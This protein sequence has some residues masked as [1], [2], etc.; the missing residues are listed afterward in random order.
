MTVSVRRSATRPATF[1]DHL[2]QALELFN[3]HAQLGERSPLATPYLLGAALNGIEPTPQGRGRVLATLITR[4][5]EA[6]WEGP[7]PADGQELLAMAMGE[8]PAAG[9]YDCL[10]LEL[11]YFQRRYRPTPRNQAEIYTD[12]LHISRPTHDRHLRAAV[13][14]L[15]NAL[16]LLLRPAIH[17]EQ[18]APPSH[19]IGREPLIAQA[20][21]NLRGCHAVNLIGRAGVG[22]SALG[23]AIS[24]RWTTPA[25]F[26]YTFRPN[27]NDQLE[28]LLFALGHFLHQQGVSAL[29][30]QLVADRKRATEGTLALGLVLAD[31]ADLTEP[32]L[33]CFDELDVL[34]P[35]FQDQP[36]PEHTALLAFLDGLRGHAPLL[37]IAQRAFWPSGTTYELEELSDQQLAAWLSALEVPHSPADVSHL[38]AYTAGNPRL[39]EL[40][41]ALHQAAPHESFAAVLEQLPR[42]QVLL[43][44]WL[45]LKQRLPQAERRLLHAL[46]VFRAPAPADAWLNGPDAPAA[47]LRQLMARRLVQHDGHGGVALL[48]ALREIIYGELPVEQR[49]EL[50]SQAA[51]VRAERGAYTAAAQHLH[52]AGQPEAAID[53]WYAQRE[54]EINQGQGARALA[55]FSQIS[56]RRLSPHH[57]KQLL[58]IRAELHELAG[59]PAHVASDLAQ[60]E[61]LAS[62]PATPEAMLRLGHA[63]EAQG[64]PEKALLTY[65]SGLDAIHALLRQSAQLHV[66]RSLTSLRQRDMQRAW[67][68]AHLARFH[69]E[70]MV[71]IV[72]DQSGDYATAHQHYRSALAL[73][74]ASGYPAG[75]AQ[76]HHYLALLAGRRQNLAEAQPHFE[77]AI[78]FYEHVGDQ[79]N[80]E[81]VRSNLAS[82]YIQARQFAEALAPATQALRFFE[83]M[84]NSV[85][86]AQNASNLAE[87]HAE[88]GNLDEA[89]RSAQLVLR[90]EEPQSHPYALYTLGTV[91]R[92][93][94][95]WKHAERYY[96][97]SRR[98]AE[99]ND[100]AYLLAFAW[101][102]LGEIARAQGSA[103]RA[104]RAF[105]QAIE[106][107]TRLAIAEEARA[108]ERLLAERDA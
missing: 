46:A 47:A 90:L 70:T 87:A 54:R 85:R 106:I 76:T 78:A 24:A 55:L 1:Y 83:A 43:P 77:Q 74:E 102:A 49:E 30:H 60:A 10:I 92:L 12:I 75:V 5:A 72:H 93:R 13:E 107:F 88:L 98:I 38:H 18:P 3:D 27:L 51:Q 56:Q 2:K 100:D 62:D 35:Q 26:W 6:L 89:E 36:Q 21:G 63:L 80:R 4:A 97:Q 96:D 25:R 52:A 95:Q 23:A 31:L 41:V 20:L 104:E 37:L 28:S 65:Q 69:A 45:R 14:R 29:W 79:V 67:R 34:Q 39:V 42:A 8:V 15:G 66:E 22:K 59:E 61:W 68:E 101:R 86:T 48:P 58:L 73:A 17:L 105:Q 9:R 81:V 99:A 103:E 94:G 91:Y 84:G 44:L 11:N 32:P 82:A 64:Q 71:G 40:C 7:L 19:L 53:L 16:L 57:Q 50:H 33:L 108:T